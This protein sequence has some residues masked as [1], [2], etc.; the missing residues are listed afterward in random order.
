MVNVF[1]EEG[2]VLVAGFDRRGEFGDSLGL[3]AGGGV[4]ADKFEGLFHG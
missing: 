4:G 2:L 1:P 3:V